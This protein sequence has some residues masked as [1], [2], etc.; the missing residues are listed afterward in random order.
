[1][2]RR[3]EERP[4]RASDPEVALQAAMRQALERSAAPGLPI[5]APDADPPAFAGRIGEAAP[6]RAVGAPARRRGARTLALPKKAARTEPVRIPDPRGRG[7]ALDL[8]V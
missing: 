6:A 8:R 2:P 1:M 7:S 4:I 3:A 5:R